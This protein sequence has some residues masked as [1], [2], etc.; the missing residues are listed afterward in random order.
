LAPDDEGRRGFRRDRNQVV[1]AR[2]SIATAAAAGTAVG[3]ESGRHAPSCLVV[4]ALAYEHGEGVPKDQLKAS[5][6]YCDAVRGVLHLYRSDRRPCD[7]RIVA[8]SP[9]PALPDAG[10]M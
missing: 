6:P 1:G 2:L 8:P 7:T 5:A 10:P 4:E 9:F 3:T